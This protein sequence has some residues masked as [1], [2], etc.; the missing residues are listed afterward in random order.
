MKKTIQYIIYITVILIGYTTCSF[1]QSSKVSPPPSVCP[2]EKGLVYGVD[3]RE[4]SGY[5]WIIKG[6]YFIN[7]SGIPYSGDTLITDTNIVI[8]DWI[9]SSDIIFDSYSLSVIEFTPLGSLGCLG[10]MTTVNI[11]FYDNSKVVLENGLVEIDL[12]VGENKTFD[13]GPGFTYY[14]WEGG[15]NSKQGADARY[16]DIA[17]TDPVSYD[18]VVRALSVDNC[19]TVDT[20]TVNYR[21]LPKIQFES[22]LINSDNSVTNPEELTL[23]VDTLKICKA[24]YEI[25]PG[26]FYDYEWSTGDNTQTITMGEIDWD[27]TI[28]VTVTNQFN[29]QS[30][31]S[32]MITACEIPIIVPT[33]FTPDQDENMT[34]ETWII[35]GIERFPD[36]VVIV[37]DRHQNKVFESKRNYQPWDGKGPNGKL[38]PVDSYHYLIRLNDEKDQ[39]FVGQVTIVY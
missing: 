26:N 38:L 32:I 6:G 39:H 14:E 3:G 11:G 31:D 24:E 18:V 35:D 8:V 4:N 13:A 36:A 25:S 28:F 17:E 27:S 9:E 30:D 21:V 10:D 37:Y 5:I 23:Y 15:D 7:E 34:N 33:A 19:E 20:I 12:C 2:G 29:C 1:S 22:K 16:F